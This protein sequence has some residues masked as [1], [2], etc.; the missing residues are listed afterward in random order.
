MPSL[1]ERQEDIPLLVNSFVA[2]VAAKSGKS[3][4]G[5][6]SEAMDSLMAYRWPG[7]VRELLNAIEYAVVLCPGGEI[8][9][10]NLP[11][12]LIAPGSISLPTVTAGSQTNLKRH[13][14]RQRQ[15]LLD[16]LK[17]CGGNQSE[18]ARRLGVSR[19]TIW[20]RCKRLGVNPKDLL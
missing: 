6:S 18:A 20:N 1:R 12:R 2:S 16:A 9:P 11:P 5:L 17:A 14:E 15:E 10:E 19:V 3:I 8:E 7:N 4:S 13:D